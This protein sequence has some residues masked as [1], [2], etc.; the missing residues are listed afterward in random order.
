MDNKDKLSYT[1]LF[2]YD[3][4]ELETQVIQCMRDGW[5]VSGGVC[6]VVDKFMHERYYQAMVR[7]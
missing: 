5:Q 3:R 4:H 1:I 7:V 6:V 2:Q